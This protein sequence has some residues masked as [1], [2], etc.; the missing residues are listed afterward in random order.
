MFPKHTWSRHVS[1]ACLEL[2]CFP[3]IPGAA[4]I[5]EHAWSCHVSGAC[6]E[7]PSTPWSNVILKVEFF[8]ALEVKKCFSERGKK[9]N[10]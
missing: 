10:R 8:S 1:G 7:A 2:L 9:N 6:V 3:I 4:M 5:P